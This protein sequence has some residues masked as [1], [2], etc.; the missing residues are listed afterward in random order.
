[1]SEFPYRQNMAHTR[2]IVD[3]EGHVLEE[4]TEPPQMDE[5]RLESR[6]TWVADGRVWESVIRSKEAK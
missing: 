5:W 4:C 6:T 1:M 3:K 2:R